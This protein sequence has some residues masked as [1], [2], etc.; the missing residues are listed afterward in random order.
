MVFNEGVNGGPHFLRPSA[1]ICPD[2][3][4][5][6]VKLIDGTQFNAIVRTR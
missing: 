4:G 2:Q 6:L 3:I 5:T 1:T